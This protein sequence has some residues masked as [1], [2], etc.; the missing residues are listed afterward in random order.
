MT[1]VTPLPELNR[2]II[3]LGSPPV[4]WF[5]GHSADH[6]LLPWLFRLPG[7]LQREMDIIRQFQRMA[8][9]R[10]E[11]TAGI[12]A[13]VA[14]HH[15]YLPQRLLAWTMDLRIALFCAL[16]REGTSPAIF[17]LDPL[18]LNAVSGLENIIAAQSTPPVP[19]IH[20][21]PHTRVQT[22]APIAINAWTKTAPASADTLFTVHGT[23]LRPL[24]EQCPESVRKVLLTPSDYAHA[25]DFL[26]GTTT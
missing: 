26:L 24:E 23:D 12:S 8:E 25:A 5:R 11:P 2:A 20:E 9:R 6:Q 4:V 7:A 15:A 17:V 19:Y 10:R 1:D 3:Q 13:L 16:A 14:M 21:W 22:R 18:G